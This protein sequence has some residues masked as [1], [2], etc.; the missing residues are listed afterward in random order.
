MLGS[1]KKLYIKE[2]LA[3][4]YVRDEEIYIITS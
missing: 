1:D 2:I 4:Q 3:T